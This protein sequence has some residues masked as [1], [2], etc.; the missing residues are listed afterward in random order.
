MRPKS[1][2]SGS[3]LLVLA[4]LGWTA[5]ALALTV[6]RIGALMIDQPDARQAFLETRSAG[7]RMEIV[8]D[9]LATALAMSVRRD[10]AP[11]LGQAQA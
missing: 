6:Y 2:R 4:A 10:S 7:E 5:P 1:R 3:L 8:A 11:N 9:A